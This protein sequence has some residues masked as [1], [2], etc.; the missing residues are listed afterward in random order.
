MNWKTLAQTSLTAPELPLI[1]VPKDI[2]MC[3]VC[4]SA[5]QSQKAS[6]SPTKKYSQKLLQLVHLD[7]AG[8]FVTSLGGASY[9]VGF[10]DDF[11]RYSVIYFL[12]TKSEAISA[13]QS[14]KSE[15]ELQTLHQI[16]CISH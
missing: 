3:M 1:T 14:Y 4:Q 12:K 10:T 16:Q 13:F 5:K 6:P 15:A 9:F 11:S 2:P 8:P 7:L